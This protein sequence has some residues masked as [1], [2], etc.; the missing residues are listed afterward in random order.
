M[1]VRAI[2]G[3]FRSALRRPGLVLLLWAWHTVLALVVTLPAWSRMHSATALAPE[4]DVLLRGV[5]LGTL[6]ELLQQEGA[7]VPTLVMT[8]MALA[9]VTLLSNAFVAGGILEVLVADDARPLLHRFFRGAGHFFFRSLRLLVTATVAFVLVGG[10]VAAALSAALRPLSSGGWEPGALLAGLLVSAVVGAVAGLA[11][12]SLDYARVR[13][14]TGDGRRMLRNWLGA[15]RFVL[16]RPLATGVIGFGL[17]GLVLATMALAAWLPLRL[18]ATNWV[19]IATASILQQLVVAAWIAVRV[20]QLASEAEFYRLA[21]PPPA[22]EP[23][24][25]PLPVHAF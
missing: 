18:G 10:L 11:F 8:M 12:V 21:M 22:P 2:A 4:T 23:A 14:V 19:A 16:G 20:W 15:L 6:I 13:L 3:G 17:F 7:V 5:Q 1:L 9:G 24:G 25:A